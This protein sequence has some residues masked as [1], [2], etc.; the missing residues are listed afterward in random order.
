MNKHDF[1]KQVDPFVYDEMFTWN[2]YQAN[3]EEYADANVLDVGGHY[4]LF[5]Y[6][7][8]T[9]LNCCR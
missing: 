7:A 6:L 4:G 1:F 9:L 5:S 2:V 8:S 3:K